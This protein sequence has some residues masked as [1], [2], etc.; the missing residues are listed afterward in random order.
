MWDL[1][2][3]TKVQA[4]LAAASL[5]LV[6]FVA[7]RVIEALRPSTSKDDTIDRDLS[8]DFEE[9]RLGGDINEEELRSI[10]S[11]LEKTHD[12]R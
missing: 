8:Q 2:S 9:M 7:Y 4:A 6:L 10:R 11:V 1:L 3:Q 12:K 5:L